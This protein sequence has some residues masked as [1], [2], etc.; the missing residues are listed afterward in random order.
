MSVNVWKAV[1]LWT[2]SSSTI[3][4][5]QRSP[6]YRL[7]EYLRTQGFSGNTNDVILSWLQSEGFGDTWNDGLYQY[8][9]SL[10]L[11]DDFADKRSAWIRGDA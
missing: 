3:P 8:W 2:G 4:V 6:W 9:E 7:A 11:P 5:D 1:N 10:G